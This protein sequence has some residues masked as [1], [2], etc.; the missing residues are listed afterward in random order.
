MSELEAYTL[1]YERIIK[2]EEVCNQFCYD[3]ERVETTILPEFW[4]CKYH[5]LLQSISARKVSV[6]R[7]RLMIEVIAPTMTTII[8]AI[9]E[10]GAEKAK[11]P[12]DLEYI[13]FRLFRPKTIG[14]PIVFDARSGTLYL[15][16]S[17]SDED[18]V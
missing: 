1:P 13:V 18:M 4:R 10:R 6:S 14:R 17:T 8:V 11:L 2:R 12:E 9:G 7:P 3:G 15:V 16:D 5:S